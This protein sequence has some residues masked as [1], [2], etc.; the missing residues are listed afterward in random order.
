MKTVI[1]SIAITV[2]MFYSFA[3]GAFAR[4]GLNMRTRGIMFN[5]V[6]YVNSSASHGS[7]FM[8]HNIVP[9]MASVT[10]PDYTVPNHAVATRADFGMV[11]ADPSPNGKKN[12]ADYR[13]CH[14]PGNP[15]PSCTQAS[16]WVG[17]STDG[18]DPGADINLVMQA[19]AGVE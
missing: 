16:Q 4:D 11:N 13:L 6:W 2:L 15:S 1:R 19:I 14:G 8:P 10:N 7:K 3:S 17:I 9:I 5:Y 18:K 12:L